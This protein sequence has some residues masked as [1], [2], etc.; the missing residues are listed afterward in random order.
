LPLRSTSDRRSEVL[1][2]DY[3]EATE[4][5]LANHSR[6]KPMTQPSWAA[7]PNS[8]TTLSAKARRSW[9]LPGGQRRLRA[10]GPTPRIPEPLTAWRGPDSFAGSTACGTRGLRCPGFG[11]GNVTAAASRRALGVAGKAVLNQAEAWLGG[12]AGLAQ[13]GRTRI[14]NGRWGSGGRKYQEI[15]HI[16]GR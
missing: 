15:G 4:R 14:T 12:C 6:A 9:A 5:P 7:V 11:A 10:T 2:R 13:P 8:D 16:G 3:G 1:R